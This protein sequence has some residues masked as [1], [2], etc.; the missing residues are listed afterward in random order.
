MAAVSSALDVP[1][2]GVGGLGAV[3]LPADEQP[4]SPKLGNFSSI[5]DD[6]PGSVSHA[7]DQ[8]VATNLRVPGPAPG[9]VTHAKAL[10]DAISLVHFSAKSAPI[11]PA[12]PAYSI[13]FLSG[14]DFSKIESP[15]KTP[16]TLLSDT[17]SEDESGRDDDEKDEADDGGGGISCTML[18]G[19]ADCFLPN[20]DVIIASAST[21][22]SAAVA[23]V[24]AR[25]AAVV[26]S[27]P[28]SP[29]TAINSRS[30]KRT[31]AHVGSSG[32][33]SFQQALLGHYDLPYPLGSVPVSIVSSVSALAGTSMLLHPIQ[34]LS[35]LTKEE[36][37]NLLELKLKPEHKRDRSFLYSRATAASVLD[38]RSS[39]HVFVDL[40]NIVIGFY[41]RIRADRGIGPE[42][43]MKAPPFFF[44][45]LSRILE[46]GR[47]TVRRVTAGSAPDSN[48]RASWPLYMRQADILG[49]EMN[50]LSRVTKSVASPALR[51]VNKLVGGPNQGHKKTSS[52]SNTDM[53]SSDDAYGPSSPPPPSSFKIGE[54]GVDEILHLKMC[55]SLLDYDIGTIVLATGDAAEA[56]FS[57]GFLKHAERALGRG[58]CVELLAWKMGISNAWRELE[59]KQK[60]TGLFRIIELDK[61]SEDLLD[62]SI[63]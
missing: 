31:P 57:D 7:S 25:A 36:K 49:Y 42:M 50:I 12:G 59:R 46:R 44:E 27:V 30:P 61:Y 62:M 19:K 40:S 2:P 48:N 47:E 32:N 41:N 11:V 54:Q 18:S 60:G 37:L 22:P 9:L 58:W 24:T 38:A 20:S 51:P 28:T 17:T 29:R 34:P 52:R 3:P 56:E 4:P 13:G 5:F 23:A 63:D 1:R 21:S 55:Q 15:S 6:W 45:A 35:W 14:L 33:I 53:Y 16:D 43:K 39:I 8:P 10:Q 26:A